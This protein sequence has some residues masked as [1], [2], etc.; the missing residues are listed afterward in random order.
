MN[1]AR[2]LNDEKC[3]LC[4]RAVA[5]LT[6][7]HLVPRSQGKKKQT[8][9]TASLCPA[10]HRQLHV[11]FSNLHLA[12]SLSSIEEIKQEPSMQRFLAWVRKQDPNKRVRHTRMTRR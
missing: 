4:E 11:L 12:R 3:E 9:P 7:H 10:C 5:N 2:P 6:V 1:P 8:L